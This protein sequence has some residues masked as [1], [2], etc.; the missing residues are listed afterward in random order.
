VSGPPDHLGYDTRLAAYCVVVDEADR[1][2]LVRWVGPV[3]ASWTLP[4]GGVEL[5]E[6]IEQAA[7]REVR[8]ETGYDVELHHLLGATPTWWRRRT[9]RCGVTGCCAWSG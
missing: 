9:A 7:V 4:G 8:E 5:G 2:L 6:T 3:R 1:V